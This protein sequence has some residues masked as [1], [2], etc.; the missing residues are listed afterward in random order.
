[1]LKILENLKI[2]FFA[3]IF[4]IFDLSDL[5]ED[6]GELFV[7]VSFAILLHCPQATSNFELLTLIL[8]GVR[9]VGVDKSI[10]HLF[11]EVVIFEVGVEWRLAV[12]DHI[13]L[14]ATYIIK[15]RILR[16]NV[17]GLD[18]VGILRVDAIGLRSISTLCIVT[19]SNF[20]A[21]LCFLLFVGVGLNFGDRKHGV[22]FLCCAFLS[23]STFSAAF[24]ADCSAF[25]G[26]GTPLRVGLGALTSG[27]SA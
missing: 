17:A 26:W 3:Q 24:F 9:A 18:H 5:F 6:F 22:I 7:F 20:D 8:D 14:N 10:L 23:L 19:D 25:A 15:I 12:V 1:M 13:P 4:Y 11:I 2:F 27:V 21:R 16:V